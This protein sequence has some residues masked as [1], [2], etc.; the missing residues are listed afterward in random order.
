MTNNGSI[1]T[2][3]IIPGVNILG[4]LRHLEYKPW[5]ALAEYVD[6]SIQ[7]FFSQ[8]RR[9]AS[10]IRLRVSIDIDVESRIITITDNAAGIPEEEIPRAFRPAE[11]PVDASGLSQFGMGMKSASCWFSPIWE[12]RTTAIGEHVERCVRFDIT[13]IIHDSLDELEIEQVESLPNEHFTVITLRDVYQMPRGR[14]LWKIRE[15]LADIYRCFLRDDSIDLFVAGT[16]L[17]YADPGALE[18]PRYSSDN[19]PQGDPVVWRKD[20]AFE[21]DGGRIVCGEAGLLPKGDTKTA[22]L[23]LYR[24]QR[25]IVG[26]GEDKYRPEEIFGRGNSYESQRVW[27]ELH[28]DDFE[29]SHTKDGFKWGGSEDEFLSK[30]REALDEDSMPLLR[31]ARNF[32]AGR[33]SSNRPA[34]TVSAAVT[35]VTRALS[36]HGAADIE[37]I[38]QSPPAQENAPSDLPSGEGSTIEERTFEIHAAGAAW[39]VTIDLSSSNSAPNWYELA[40]GQD[41]AHLTRNLKLRIYL[42]HPFMRR[43]VRIDDHDSLEPVLRIAAA[44]GLSEVLARF[45]GSNVGPGEIRRNVNELLGSS[46][47]HRTE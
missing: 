30:L 38:E 19:E 41:E 17:G 31:Q 36:E 13:E 44:L 10:G 33:P 32:R 27:G 12:V 45:A 9:L 46:L 4:V 24:R 23:C 26:T 1:S 34:P 3:K 7:S 35:G 15:H 47:S 11:P 8:R 29:V 28:M 5:Y 21:C 18:A 16:K 20:I 25:A 6:N 40:C 2:V 39:S 42:N 14:T 37:R 22:G 43:I